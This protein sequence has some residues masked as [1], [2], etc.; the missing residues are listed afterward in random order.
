[1][2]AS[3]REDSTQGRN[4]LPPTVVRSPEPPALEL[5]DHKLEPLGDRYIDQGAFARGGMSRLGLAFDRRLGQQRVVKTLKP[6]L[7]Q[8]KKLVHQFITEAQRTAGLTH[9]G[10]IPVH[11]LG[12][13]AQGLP[14]FSMSRIHGVDLSKWLDAQSERGTPQTELLYKAIGILIKICDVLA[15]AHDQGLI[16]SDLKPANIMVGAY[17]EAYLLDWGVCREKGAPHPVVAGTPAYMSPEQAKGQPLDERADVFSLGAI[18]YELLTG[19]PPHLGAT[20]EDA[21]EQAQRGMITDPIYVAGGVPRSL[22]NLTM[23]ALARD[24]SQRQASARQLR[25]EL[26]AFLRGTW[27]FEQE[28][29]RRGSLL[30]REGEPGDCA[31]TLIRG[32]CEVFKTA[33][34]SARRLKVLGPGDSFGEI[35]I[36]ADVPRSASV[37]ALSDVEV[38]VVERVAFQDWLALDPCLASFMR[39][40]AERVLQRDAELL[41][42]Q[43]ERTA[44]QVALQA[45][46]ELHAS[47]SASFAGIVQSVGQALSIDDVRIAAI[48]RCHPLFETDPGGDGISLRAGPEHQVSDR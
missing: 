27:R 32:Q 12:L 43:N 17:G 4:D 26:E 8:T 11:D 16:H 2:T 21:L 14:G 42:A 30:I 31:Y 37:R 48:L 23:R 24:P 38:R 44:A 15:Y 45:V 35:A 22:S 41:Q 9:P 34:G 1:M 29:F 40:L 47:P 28:S 19:A 36:L 33:D 25:E 5:A 10:V 3:K 6:D 46:L 13:D 39:F 18:L 20:Q 7:A